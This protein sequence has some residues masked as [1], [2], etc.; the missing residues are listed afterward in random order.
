MKARSRSLPIADKEN[1]GK[2]PGFSR[3]A[4]ASWGMLPAELQRDSVIQV[5]NPNEMPSNLQDFVMLKRFSQYERH[6]RCNIVVVRKHG[7]RLAAACNVLMRRSLKTR[8]ADCL[9]ASRDGVAEAYCG[10][11]T[12]WM[13]CSNDCIERLH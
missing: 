1:R 7:R 4:S 12:H 2:R 8:G 5:W 10:C 3:K 11:A 6:W 13:R 9:A